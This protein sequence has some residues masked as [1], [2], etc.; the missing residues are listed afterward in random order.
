MGRSKQMVDDSNMEV[1]PTKSDFQ[2]VAKLHQKI[3]T[4]SQGIGKLENDGKNSFSNYKYISNVQMTTAMRSYLLPNKL[5]IVASVLDMDE[6]EFANDKG[7]LTV[8]STVTMA[9]Q[10]VDLETGYSIMESF[11]G[12]EQDTGGK[13]LQQA[14]TQCTKYF[15]FKLFNVSSQ[16]DIDPDSKTTEVNQPK[17]VAK[18]VDKS[19]LTASQFDAI[20]RE[21]NEYKIAYLNKVDNKEMKCSTA[22][23]NKIKQSISI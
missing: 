6:R 9:F 8:R 11:V 23:Y 3:Q 12:A 7:K 17:V 20:M 22:S 1:T 21:S 13:S 18:P 4:C 16:D 5:S 14:I 15:Y 10:I 19:K 2:M